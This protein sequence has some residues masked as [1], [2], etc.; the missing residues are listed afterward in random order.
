LALRGESCLILPLPLPCRCLIDGSI[1][2]ETHR[3]KFD[4][5]PRSVD[6]NTDLIAPHDETGDPEAL[7]MT[8][9]PADPRMPNGTNDSHPAVTGNEASAD[10]SDYEVALDAP[11]FLNHKFGS[12]L[13]DVSPSSNILSKLAQRMRRHLLQDQLP[14]ETRRSGANIERIMLALLS[15]LVIVSCAGAIAALMQVKSLKSELA[16]VQRELLPLRERV[17]RLDQR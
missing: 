11:D 5:E 12:G 8:S 15:L 16:A 6:Q 2:A 10:R 3:K 14:T 13:R 4:L 9:P 17:A 7:S 1:S